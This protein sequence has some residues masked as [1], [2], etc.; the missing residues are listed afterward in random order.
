MTL[1]ISIHAPLTGSDRTFRMH[2]SP[3]RN[4]NPRS[5][6]GERRFVPNPKRWPESKISIHAPLT[7]SDGHLRI[8]VSFC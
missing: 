4:F 8:L 1:K 5:P 6:Y 7:G 3:A 2:L